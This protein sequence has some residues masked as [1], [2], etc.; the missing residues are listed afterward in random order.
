MKKNEA[1]YLFGVSIFSV[2][3]YL[4]AWSIPS[5]TQG[6]HDRRIQMT[7]VVLLYR[8]DL[9][10]SVKTYPWC[11]RIQ[12][13]P[14]PLLEL[15]LLLI[16]EHQFASGATLELEHEFG[17]LTVKLVLDLGCHSI[18]PIGDL[19]LVSARE[20]DARAFWNL[21]LYGDRAIG[22][23]HN[24]HASDDVLFVFHVAGSFKTK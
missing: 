10:H 20:P 18:E 24:R 19:L 2:K 16:S 23:A 17:F 15:E 14:K 12:G 3:R 5:S 1:T 7:K 13:L 21:R 22:H 6:K 9:S 11:I 8:A 4:R